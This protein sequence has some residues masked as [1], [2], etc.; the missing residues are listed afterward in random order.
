MPEIYMGKIIWQI[1]GKYKELIKSK[2]VREVMKC[3][4]AFSKKLAEIIIPEFYHLKFLILK[5]SK[6]A[7][8][9]L[10]LLY[11]LQLDKCELKW[12]LVLQPSLLWKIPW[13]FKKILVQESKT[14]K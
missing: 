10:F 2:T 5:P 7:S 9:S 8:Y 14:F 4:L 13:L 1:G 3:S 11:I 6:S 12:Q